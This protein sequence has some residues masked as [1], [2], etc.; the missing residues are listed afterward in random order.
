MK[1]NSL[2]VALLWLALI[3]TGIIG[4]VM[5]IVAIFHSNFSVISGE[6]VLRVIGVFVAPLGSIMGLF[7]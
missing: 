5:N 6:L 2:T 7:V 3:V 1:T 4:W